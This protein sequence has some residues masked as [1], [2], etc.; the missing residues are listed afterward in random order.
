MNADRAFTQGDWA[1][2]DEPCAPGLFQAAVR[3]PGAGASLAG[4]TVT[5]EPVWHSAA[6]DLASGAVA[7]RV[8]PGVSA[9]AFAAGPATVAREIGLAL[10]FADHLRSHRT[11]QLGLNRPCAVSPQR[12]PQVPGDAV[13]LLSLIHI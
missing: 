4:T 7:A 11:A 9:V 6:R 2:V 5:G 13:R 1:R 10:A 3:R 12:P 8:N